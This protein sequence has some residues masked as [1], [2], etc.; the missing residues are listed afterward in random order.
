MRSIL[1]CLPLLFAAE[2]TAQALPACGDA[3]LAAAPDPWDAAA[4][5]I[6]DF[7][8]DGSSDVAFWKHEE[9]SVLLYIAA[10]DG[11]RAVETWR[12]RVPVNTASDDWP[13]QVITPLLDPALVNR[14]CASGETDECV[15]MRRENERR[16]S[17]ADAGGRELRV[18]PVGTG[19]RFRWSSAAHGFMRIG[20]R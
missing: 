16:Q 14:V 8:L 2:A 15:H 9:A 18:G 17:I 6:G 5:V 7:T 1:F 12:F 3:A 11:D 10:C 13:V 20:G 19:V 4:A